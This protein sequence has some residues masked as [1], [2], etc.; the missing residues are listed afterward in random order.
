MSWPSLLL[1]RRGYGSNKLQ[2]SCVAQGALMIKATAVVTLFSGT[3][4]L[5]NSRADG[6]ATMQ[7][8]LWA[9]RVTPCVTLIRDSSTRQHGAS[10][11]YLLFLSTS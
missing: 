3:Q 11:S 4:F 7:H 10:P 1:L 9:V 8:G 6:L 5:T 2:R